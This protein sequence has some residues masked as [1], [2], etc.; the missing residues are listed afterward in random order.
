MTQKVSAGMTISDPGWQI[1]RP[2][3][4]KEGHAAVGGGDRRARAESRLERPLE[5]LDL[6][7]PDQF[8]ARRAAA[9]DLVGRVDIRTP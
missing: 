4:V 1:E 5:L 6:R 8:A 3:D 2:Q 9:D 7:S